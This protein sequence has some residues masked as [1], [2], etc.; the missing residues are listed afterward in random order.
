MAMATMKSCSRW[1]MT[2][3]AFGPK[4]ESYINWIAPHLRPGGRTL[5]I[6]CSTGL[7]PC[8][9]KERGFAAEGL[10]LNSTT[11]EF[12][13]SQFGIPVTS[14]PFETAD[15]HRRASAWSR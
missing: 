2:R 8:L 13:R 12:A 5:D 14:Q 9:L 15:I 3:A 7:L 6:G 11:A 1:S 10:E 4:F